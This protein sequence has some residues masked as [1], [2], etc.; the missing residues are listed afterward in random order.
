MT[1]DGCELSCVQAYG[2]CLADDLGI[3]AKYLLLSV[4]VSGGAFGC[5]CALTC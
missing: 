2:G 1:L 4:S 5:V 3:Y